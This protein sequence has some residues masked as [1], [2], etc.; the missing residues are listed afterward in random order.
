MGAV[1]ALAAVAAVA[2]VAVDVDE[3]GPDDHARRI[4]D[5][6]IVFPGELIAGADHGDAPVDDEDVMVLEK[7]LSGDDRRSANAG[8]HQYWLSKSQT[9][10]EAI[11]SDT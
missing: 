10:G 2:A 9:T 3:A 1:M 8:P 11:L 5:L 6:R 4:H 7:A